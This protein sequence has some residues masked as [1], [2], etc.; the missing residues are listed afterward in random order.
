MKQ[1]LKMVLGFLDLLAVACFEVR[2]RDGIKVFDND[3][4][5]NS[6]GDIAALWEVEFAQGLCIHMQHGVERRCDIFGDDLDVNLG[7]DALRYFDIADHGAGLAAF[8]GMD[9]HPPLLVHIDF[10]NDHVAILQT[11]GGLAMLGVN[12]AVSSATSSVG[13]SVSPLSLSSLEIGVSIGWQ[14][15]SAKTRMINKLEIVIIFLVN[16]FLSTLLHF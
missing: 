1:S 2:F 4:V 12:Y 14:A 15:A 16:F 13:R 3:L 10:V 6:Y 9:H 11:L 7:A 5:I 8:I